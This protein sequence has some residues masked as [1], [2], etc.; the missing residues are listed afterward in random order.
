MQTAEQYNPIYQ[1]LQADLHRYT[2]VLHVLEKLGQDRQLSAITDVFSGLMASEV[3]YAVKGELNRAGA[4][5]YSPSRF[6]PL[7]ADQHAGL[8]R[9]PE[10]DNCWDH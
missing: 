10:A 4:A 1:S 7:L 8:Q 2:A 9:Q 3:D 6:Q 5:R